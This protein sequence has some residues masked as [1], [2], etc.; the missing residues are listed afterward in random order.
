MLR[1]TS[2]S[3][4]FNRTCP[5]FSFFNKVPL[6][7]TFQVNC[8]RFY[9]PLVRSNSCF[10]GK[11]GKH[12]QAC[13]FV[14]DRRA[15]LCILTASATA[16][17]YESSEPA[18]PKVSLRSMRKARR[19][20]PEGVLSTKLNDCSKKG[21]LAEALR[22]YD[23]AR[24]N[25]VKLNQQHYNSMLYLCS[26]G[27]P[28]KLDGDGFSESASYFDS[29]RGF[30]IFRQMIIDNVAPNEAT[31]TNVA[32]LALVME[33]PEMAFDLIKQ[34]INFK[35]LP[36]LRSYGPALFGFCKIGMADKVYEV[37][38]HMAEY[39]V[40]PE[41]AE[42]CALLKVSA[43]VNRADK[44]YETLHRLR[45]TVRQVADSTFGVIEAWFRSN[46]ASKVGV[47]SWDVS[48]VSEGVVKGGGGWHGQGWLG[49]GQ[50]RVIRTRVNEK[51]VCQS[52]NEKLVCIDIDPKETEK[53][54]S[55][56]ANLA[57][58]REVKA[59]FVRFE[60]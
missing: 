55:S 59:D 22:L 60:V 46:N 54:A 16:K 24:S 9:H 3:P 7:S 4:S 42:L 34:M 2:F 36:R 37:D 38:A 8:R 11:P 27:S 17:V 15:H 40:M 10:V 20:S 33:D 50:W 35:I 52:C 1:G 32:R 39:E 43:D 25:N 48:K 5:I 13:N 56:L 14:A 51:G 19:E 31:F 49:N 58:Q 26:S 6:L 30:D 57:C 21:D 28:V 41:E 29:K 23:E 12:I 47:E 44:V 18:K 53:F 45:A